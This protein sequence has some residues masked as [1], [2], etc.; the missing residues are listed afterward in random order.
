MGPLIRKK[1]L[2]KLA[3]LTAG[4]V[5]QAI[6][7]GRIK[8]ALVGGKIDSEHPETIE[9]IKGGRLRV[10]QNAA[11]RKKTGFGSPK[12]RQSDI[13]YNLPVRSPEFISDRIIEIPED[14]RHCVDMSLRQIIE[15]YGTAPTFKEWLSAV[16]QIDKIYKV[17]LENAAKEGTLVSRELVQ[18]GVIDPFDGAHRNL[19]ADGSRTLV[20]EL[21]AMIKSGDTREDCES[22]ARDKMSSFL[23]SAKA[24]ALRSLG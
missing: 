17:R 1:D 3:G 6:S 22:Y 5:T 9:F 18:Q 23:K 19:L 15:I 7:S 16:A 14:L 24:T 11:G 13:N 10:E 8:H 4:A 20:T 2:A 12:L 21:T